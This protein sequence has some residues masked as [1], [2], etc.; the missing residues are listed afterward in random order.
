MPSIAAWLFNACLYAIVISLLMYYAVGPSFQYY[1]LFPMGTTVFVGLCNALQLKVAL[2]NHQWEWVRVF[3]MV[4]SVSG[5]L[6]YLNILSSYVESDNYYVAYQLFNVTPYSSIFWTFSFFFIPVF[7]V[8]IDVFGNALKT[9]FRPTNEIRYF[10]SEHLREYE[11]DPIISK[12]LFNFSRDARCNDRR[13]SDEQ[14]DQ[15][16]I[17]TIE[18][19]PPRLSTVSAIEMERVYRNNSNV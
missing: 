11:K 4:L 9:L 13:T 16:R 8:Y 5:M 6:L 15:P 1:S 19:E 10:E 12:S 18:S 3:M 14:D 7:V 2:L 17:S